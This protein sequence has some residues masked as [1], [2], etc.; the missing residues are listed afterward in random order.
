M[1]DPIER[2]FPQLGHRP[3]ALLRQLD[4]IQPAACQK[5][6]QL[7][8][9]LPERPHSW[10]AAFFATQTRRL[11]KVEGGLVTERAR[12]ADIAWIFLASWLVLLA[13]R[14]A[15]LGQ[16]SSVVAHQ[17]ANGGLLLFA[18]FMISDP[19]TIPRRRAARAAYAFV[20]ATFA[21]AWQFALF[22]TNGLLWALFLFSPLVPLIDRYWPGPAFTWRPERDAPAPSPK[23]NSVRT[24]A[25]GRSGPASPLERQIRRGPVG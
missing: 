2:G 15:W 14:A 13:A 9:V 23:L 12:R 5:T 17:L 20:V 19:M 18:F 16:P 25:G 8:G 24:R 3:S 11:G 4:F 6:S 22:R 21:F 7:P 10:L 1:F